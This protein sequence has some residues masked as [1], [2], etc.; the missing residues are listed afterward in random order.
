M[1][2][3][4]SRPARRFWIWAAELGV[5]GFVVSCWGEGDG[6]A[7]FWGTP[8]MVAPGASGSGVEGDG[9]DE[10]E[11]DYVA[12]EGGVVAVAEGCADG[13]F[14]CCGAC[15]HVCTPSPRV[16]RKIFETNDLGSD[17]MRKVLILLRAVL[18]ILPNA[19]FRCVCWP[20]FWPAWRVALWCCPHVLLYSGCQGFLG[21]S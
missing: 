15:R 5:G 4:V 14:H 8:G 6:G 20:V 3:M 11:V 21:R 13:L 1:W 16:L 17:L 18:Q 7:E 9:F 2:R 19:G 10:A 12:G